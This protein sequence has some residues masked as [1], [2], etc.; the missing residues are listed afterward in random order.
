MNICIHWIGDD[1]CSS[2]HKYTQWQHGSMYI[3]KYY[4]RNNNG[5]LCSMVIIIVKMNC[6]MCPGVKNLVLKVSLLQIRI[7]PSTGLQT[8]SQHHSLG[9][10]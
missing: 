8:S 4:N 9:S 6:N 2:T 3:L 7:E 10:S 5:V 1:A